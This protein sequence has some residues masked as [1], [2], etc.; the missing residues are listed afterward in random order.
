VHKLLC[1]QYFEMNY[2]II[3]NLAR[4]IPAGRVATYGQLARVA[5]WGRRARFVG[6]AM[7]AAPDDV[8]WHRVINARGEI[9]RRSASDSHELQRLLL[10][11]E[12]VEF[13]KKGRVDLKRFGWTFPLIRPEPALSEAEGATFSPRRGEKGNRR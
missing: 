9:S 4:R 8:P 5:G 10:E 2:N 11:A 7:H 6:Y 13:D 3:Y 1:Y 12:G